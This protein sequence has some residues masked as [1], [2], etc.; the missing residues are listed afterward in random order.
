K[1][2]RKDPQVEIE[3]HDILTTDELPED[4]LAY[5]K[6]DIVVSMAPL[7]NRSIVCTHFNRM[8]CI[9]VCSE[10]HPRL[11]DTATIDEILQ[12]SFTQLVARAS[13]I[14]EYH[15]LIDD[16][17]GERIIGFRSKSL[18]TIANAISS[19]E[20]IG[21]LPESLVDYYSSSIKLKKVTTPFT[22]APVQLYLMYNRA[23]LNNS[24]FAELIEHITKKH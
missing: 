7:N 22:I 1:Y 4:L 18:M 16:T 19:T 23:S 5:R 10:N 20:L 8:E 2:I 11:G 9:L 15:S 14:K 6:A 3:Y 17:L 24:G 21:F 12:E 13:G